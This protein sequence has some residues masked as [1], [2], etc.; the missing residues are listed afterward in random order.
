M[1]LRSATVDRFLGMARTHTS[2]PA[3]VALAVM[4]GAGAA[5]AC[6]ELIAQLHPAEEPSRSGNGRQ[7]PNKNHGATTPAH[8]QINS[9]EGT[10]HKND[11]GIK[12]TEFIQTF[13][14]VAAAVFAWLIY[15]VYDRQRNIMDKQAAILTA[16]ERAT[17]A[18]ERAYIFPGQTL[19]R[20]YTGQ[21]VLI[22]LQVCGF[23]SIYPASD[24]SSCSQP[25]W[26]SARVRSQ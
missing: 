9:E 4:V 22:D 25:S 13:S 14:S 1:L 24:W 11:D 5:M 23:A 18:I 2:I 6:F 26:I 17:E 8:G 7:P 20:S 10:P 21:E 16:H 15:Q 3:A 12:W 19:L